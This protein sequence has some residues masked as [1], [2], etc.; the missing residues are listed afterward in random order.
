MLP[1]DVAHL[2]VT[3]ML[4]DGGLL[5]LRPIRPEDGQLLADGF[6]RLSPESRFLRFFSP[7]NHLS[8]MQLRY[9]T[10]IDYVDHFA[11]VAT[12]ATPDDPVLGVGVARYIRSRDEP[13]MAE[14]AVAVTDD[15]HRRGIGSVLLEAL[16]AV[17]LTRGITAFHLLV[18]S[19]NHSMIAAMAD[20]GADPRPSDDP[21][22]IRFVLDLPQLIEGL[23]G[24]PMW[25]VFRFVGEGSVD[26]KSSIARR[27]L[28]DPP[29]TMP[30]RSR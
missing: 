8:E 29:S 11:W 26:L 2:A 19:D 3:T 28:Q 9:F 10:E 25:K 24:T 5:S 1:D 16:G 23:R 18:R 20:L 30:T 13:T 22:I 17:A 7:L 14:A 4:P 21:G 27:W 15:H 6:G 12:V